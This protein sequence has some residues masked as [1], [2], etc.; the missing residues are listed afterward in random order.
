[1]E[2]NNKE[3]VIENTDQLINLM[4][5]YLSEWEHRDS[6]LWKQVFTY[7]FATL[8]VMILPFANIWDFSLGDK[9]EPWIFPVIG[10]LM[11]LVFSVIGKGYA[12][13]LQAIGHTYGELID[14]LPKEF[15]R[16][17]IEQRTKCCIMTKHFSNLIVDLMTVLL[18]IL[19]I[20]LLVISLIS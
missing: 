17:K 2:T 9:I 11:T 6:M 20:V 16:Q 7:F 4:N 13:R 1:M 15:K 3:F 8:I 19:G 14:K 18:L 5:V 10:L 12:I